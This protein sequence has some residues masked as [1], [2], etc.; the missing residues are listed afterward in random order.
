MLQLIIDK[1]DDRETMIISKKEWEY[2]KNI[3]FNKDWKNYES[4]DWQ[5]YS[6]I[7]KLL[8]NHLA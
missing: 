6:E 3:I 8:D 1:T 4:K 2:V 5:L 7:I